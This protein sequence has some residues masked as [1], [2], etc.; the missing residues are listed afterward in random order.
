MSG[1][2][3]SFRLYN[4][5]IL[6]ESRKGAEMPLTR[7]VSLILLACSLPLTAQT[8]TARLAGTVED[9]SGALIPRAKLSLVNDR[10]QV[11]WDATANDEGY[12]IFAALQPDVYSLTVSAQGFRTNVIGNIE[13]IVGANETQ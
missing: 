5:S 11:H 13:L 8:P 3:P 1:L 6:V 2:A 9:P 4:D 7:S 12:F 10:T